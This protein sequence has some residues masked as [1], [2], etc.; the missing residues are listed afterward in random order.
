MEIKSE[1][2]RT[3]AGIIPIDW[4]TRKIG[5]FAKITSGGTPS[6]L[7]AAFWGGSIKWMS[8]G[9]LNKKVV[10][11]VEGRITEVGL[12][13]SSAKLIPPR[14][15]L[16]G[17]AGQGKTRGTVAMNMVELCT[18]QSIAAILPNDEFEPEYLYYNLDA[19]YDELRAL[20]SG[21][22]G[23]GGLNLSIIKSIIVPLPEKKE[24]RDIAT[25]LSD[26]DALITALNQ[27]IS[28][29]RDI[30]KGTMQE[31]LTGKKRLPGFNSGK[32]YKKTE[33]GMIPEDWDIPI[34]GEIFSFKNGLNK[35]KES[36]GHGTHIV[37]YMDVYSHPGIYAYDLEGRV[38]VNRSELRSFAVKKGDVFFTRTSE[39]VAEVGIASV[40][41]DDS[42]NT[43]FSGFILRARPKNKSIC[44]QF[45]KYCFSSDIVRKQITSK[46]TY[47]TRA[48]TSGRVLS[49]ISL[50]LPPTKAEQEAIAFLLSDMDAEIATL[51]T[52]M[53]KI[54]ML[55]QG[56]MQTLITGS[57]RLT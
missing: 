17:L 1:S 53:S 28:K 22:G 42:S 21:G 7:I 41:L 52:K 9:E 57:I 39:T 34:L 20:S 32:S 8:S 54:R 45:K 33:I 56:M 49:A 5:D 27:L 6:T 55:K 38:E 26:I 18:N 24:Q 50:P 4:T 23:R 11:D 2:K 13:S 12:H 47:T 46:A 15:V 3:E 43:V 40:M 10:W 48:L 31:L 44:D 16:V 37:N 36:F 29:K 30:R 35:G 19:R 51:E 14:C 25:A